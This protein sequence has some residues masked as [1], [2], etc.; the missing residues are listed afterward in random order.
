M[1]TKPPTRKAYSYLQLWI[2]LTW[3]RPGLGRLRYGSSKGNQTWC[4]LGDADAMV[5]WCR[6]KS[7]SSW[8]QLIGG[9]HPIYQLYIN[10]P[11]WIVETIG[12]ETSFL[13]ISSLNYPLGGAGFRWP[14]HSRIF[15]SL[16]IG[17]HRSWN[18]ALF[19]SLSAG[20]PDSCHCPSKFWCVILYYTVLNTIYT[21][22]MYIWC[23]YIYMIMIIY[24]YIHII[25][26]QRIV[27]AWWFFRV[28]LTAHCEKPPTAA[29]PTGF[30]ETSA[31]G[32]QAP[33][34]QGVGGSGG[35][36]RWAIRWWCYALRSSQ[37][38][39]PT[40]LMLDF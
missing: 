21:K 27:K 12:G 11:P 26:P 18:L 3:C 28:I 5:I 33:D 32:L 23:I 35:V 31:A 20:V 17:E 2:H 1:A 34:L 37:A 10:I 19:S 15:P 25:Y 6:W 40:Q 36:L 24:I 29:Y 9:K 22:Y 30:V 38:Y 39:F 13:E 16:S 7:C 14:I 4:D 8:I